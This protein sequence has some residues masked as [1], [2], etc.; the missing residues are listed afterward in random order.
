MA[1][2][3]EKKS[4][5]LSDDPETVEAAP[6]VS[7]EAEMGKVSPVPEAAKP[8]ESVGNASIDGF[9]ELSDKEFASLNNQQREDYI[10]RRSKFELVNGPQTVFMVPLQAGEK[11]GAVETVSLNGYRINVKK[12]KMVTIPVAMAQI[13]GE[14]YQIEMEAGSSMLLDR[15][16][17]TV[18]AL[19]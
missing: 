17:N 7:A 5:I 6:E 8:I 9:K 4:A 1:S 12:G 14:K 13:I 10:A 18:E 2:K 15:D 19:S 3:N 16:E 11:P